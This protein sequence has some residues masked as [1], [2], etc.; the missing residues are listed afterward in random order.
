MYI[1]IGTS[2]SWSEHPKSPYYMSKES[3][4]IYFGSN[5]KGIYIFPKNRHAD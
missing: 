1:K 4:Q 5:L 2:K 3:Y